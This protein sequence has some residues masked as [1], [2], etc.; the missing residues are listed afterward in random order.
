MGFLLKFYQSHKFQKSFR[1]TQFTERRRV[2]NSAS[3]N[4]GENT[5][6]DDSHKRDIL[7]LSNNSKNYFEPS[8]LWAPEA[9][10][11]ITFVTDFAPENKNKKILI[12]IKY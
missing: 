3:D 4:C 1:E 11:F 9:T 12:P 8:S 2:Q 7:P 6:F 10:S 5:A